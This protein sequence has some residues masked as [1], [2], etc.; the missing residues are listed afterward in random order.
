MAYTKEEGRA[1]VLKAGLE[2][3]REGL[4]ARTWGNI[5]ARISKDQ[6]VITPSGRSYDTLKPEDIV[7]V[8]IADMSYEGRIRPSSEK[9]VHTAIYREREDVNFIIHTH[10]AYASAL[11]ILDQDVEAKERIPVSL[12]GRN[13]SEEIMEN[14]KNCVAS[15]P[16]CHAALMQ[17]HGAVCFDDSMEKTFERCRRLEAISKDWYEKTCGKDLPELF[18]GIT[19]E[20]PAGDFSFLEKQKIRIPGISCAALCD[21]PYVRL[22]A[23]HLSVL[24]AYIDDFAQMTGVSAPVLESID[25]ANALKD[26]LSACPAV[27]IRNRGAILSADTMEDLAALSMVLEKNCLAALLAEKTGAKP[28][29]EKDAAWDHEGYVTGYAKLAKSNV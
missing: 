10:Q 7:V 28:V 20:N 16:G 12:Y 3:V 2:L 24:P 25:D 17:H 15:H 21:T 23:E 26:A 29:E 6:F 5:S 1:L 4:I 22:A 18:F 8:S 9:G 13:G 27:L 19:A 14:M 11:S